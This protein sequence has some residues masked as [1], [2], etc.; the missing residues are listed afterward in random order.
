MWPKKKHEQKML[1]CFLLIRE[2]PELQHFVAGIPMHVDKIFQ[3]TN[4]LSKN[5]KMKSITYVESVYLYF[6]FD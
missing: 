1:A 2:G 4:G 5:V 3:V 6:D